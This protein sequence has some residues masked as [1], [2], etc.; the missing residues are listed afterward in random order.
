MH[1]NSGR[2]SFGRGHSSGGEIPDPGFN[3]IDNVLSHEECKAILQGLERSLVS[4]GRAGARHLL[5][6]PNVAHLARDQRLLTL[7]ATALGGKAVPFRATLFEKSGKANWLVVWHQDTALPMSTRSEGAGWGPWSQ[8]AGI[9]YAHAPA[10]ALA[11]VVALRLHLDPSTSENGPLRVVPDSHTLGVL[12]DR[13]IRSAVDQRGFR[14]CLAPRG[15]ILVMRPLLIHASSKS[16]TDAPRRVLHF[17][18]CDSLQ[19][20]PSIELAV[21]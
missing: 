8:K 18:Y 13:E 3:I 16:L 7:A 9:L 21:S 4:R 14:E 17:E 12:S 11:H 1:T 6:D 20:S 15:G 10:W 2:V 19:L 5:A